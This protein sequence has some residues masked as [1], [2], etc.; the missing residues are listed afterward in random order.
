MPLMPELLSRAQKAA[1]ELAEAE[2]QLLVSR[3]E[4]HTAIRRL[5][6]GGSSLREVAEALGL[7]HQR[8][9]QIVDGSGGSWWRKAWRTRRPTRDAVCTW[10]GRPPSEVEKLVAGPNV[11]LCDG[12][13]QQAERAL[14]AAGGSSGFTATRSPKSRCS[15]CSRRAGSARQLVIHRA[16]NVCTQCLQQCRDIMQL[17]EST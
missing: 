11:Y 8:I 7:S 15:F 4:Y 1:T 17:G 10:C 13:L 14:R 9:Q 12:C 5:H 6:L 3:A 16:A 2:R